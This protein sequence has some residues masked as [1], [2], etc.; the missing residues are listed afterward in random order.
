[1]LARKLCVVGFTLCN[2][3]NAVEKSSHGINNFCGIRDQ[4]FQWFWDQGSKFKVKNE[5]SFETIYLVTTLIYPKQKLRA[6]K[7]GEFI[8]QHIDNKSQFRDKKVTEMYNLLLSK[9]A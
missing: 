3:I 9:K 7:E 6:T 8:T 4:N 5:N 1:M 2:E